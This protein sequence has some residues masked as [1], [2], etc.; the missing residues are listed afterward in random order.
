[1]VGVRK[2][3]WRNKIRCSISIYGN[4]ARGIDN[5]DV[6]DETRRNAETKKYRFRL[7]VPVCTIDWNR[8]RKWGEQYVERERERQWDHTHHRSHTTH[9]NTIRISIIGVSNTSVRCTNYFFFVVVVVVVIRCYFSLSFPISIVVLNSFSFLA[10]RFHSLAKCN[11]IAAVNVG[12][13]EIRF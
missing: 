5:E 2:F 1:M 6:D 4:W 11:R 7:H 3:F 9:R 8:Q 13:F 10:C 12:K